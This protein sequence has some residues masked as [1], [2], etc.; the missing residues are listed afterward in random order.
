[1]VGSLGVVA[2]APASEVSA[3]TD[4]DFTLPAEGTTV[5]ANTELTLRVRKPSDGEGG[6]GDAGTVPD[7]MCMNLQEAQ[8][9]LRDAGYRTT[10]K[11]HTSQGR[12]QVLDRNWL[13]VLQSPGA[14]TP[15][16]KGV[17]A[18]ALHQHVWPLL[19]QG[20]VATV[21]HEVFPLERAADAHR[22]M[23]SSTHVGKLILSVR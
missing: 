20:V 11:D 2:I 14:G 1:M 23:E 13:V 15:A 3:H 6:A 7:V 18:R 21:I 8:D 12:R 5:H 17:I 10:S 9:K 19:E 16:E 22:M 4:L